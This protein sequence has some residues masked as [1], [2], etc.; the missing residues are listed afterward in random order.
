MNRFFD[1]RFTIG[2]F[3]L[4]LGIMLL[5][6]SL[7]FDDTNSRVN[8]YSSV[9]FILFAVFMLFGTGKIHPENS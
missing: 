7:L 1:L 4:I 3:F 9:A 5:I 6:Y 8:I 2:I